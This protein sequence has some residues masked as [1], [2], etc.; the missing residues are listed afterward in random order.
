LVESHA[1]NE[2]V[3][4]AWVVVSGDFLGRSRR[5]ISKGDQ[6]CKMVRVG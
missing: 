2:L 1:K 4:A 5:E 3:L 6:E